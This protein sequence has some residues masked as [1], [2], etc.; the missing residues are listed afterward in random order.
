MIP[1]PDWARRYGSRTRRLCA[2]PG[3]GSPAAATLRF[4]PTR[5]QAWLVDLVTDVP[6]REGDLCARHAN[7]LVLPRGWRLHDERTVRGLPVRPSQAVRKS[8]RATR[9]RRRRAEIATLPLPLDLAAGATPTADQSETAPAEAAPSEPAAD[10]TI[11]LI[12]TRHI[13]RRRIDESDELDEV[14]QART[15]LLQRA[16]GNARGR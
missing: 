3:C 4:E 14:L 8:V 9:S 6:R 2:R 16:F 12:D 7:A 5:R 11:T 1:G 13:P 10:A 15:P